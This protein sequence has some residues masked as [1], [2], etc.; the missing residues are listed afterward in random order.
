MVNLRLLKKWNDKNFNQ[1]NKLIEKYNVTADELIK[2]KN[3]D[4][5]SEIDEDKKAEVGKLIKNIRNNNTLKDIINEQ[6]RI[7]LINA[8]SDI[9]LN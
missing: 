3:T 2:G 6:Y 8:F 5:L 9:Q 7:V 1:L 4:K